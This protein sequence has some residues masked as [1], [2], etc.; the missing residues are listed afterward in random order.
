MTALRVQ[1]HFR[2]MPSMRV[3]NE[4]TRRAKAMSRAFHCFRGLLLSAAKLG[5]LRRVASKLASRARGSFTHA[6]IWAGL[7][8]TDRW[9]RT[10]TSFP[11]AGPSFRFI[12][13]PPSPRP[14]PRSCSRPTGPG[15]G[16]SS[17]GWSP[18]EPG[19]ASSTPRPGGIGRRRH[20]P[21][22][23]SG[24]HGCSNP[25]RSA[26][27][28]SSTSSSSAE[29]RSSSRSTPRPRPGTCAQRA[30]SPAQRTGHGASPRRGASRAPR[31]QGSFVRPRR[32]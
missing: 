7:M 18:A 27:A 29:M 17:R 21:T 15:P 12:V 22:S 20:D 26:S 6:R 25:A 24:T 23:S 1:P 30:A 3:L 19:R 11:M 31:G 2:T 4:S 8:F 16:A 13:V 10:N 9:N 32:P 28:P 14:S 5:S